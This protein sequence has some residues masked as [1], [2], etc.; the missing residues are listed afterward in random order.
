MFT[1]VSPYANVK[2]DCISYLSR[3]TILT[4]G[5]KREKYAKSEG[6]ELYYKL[7]REAARRTKTDFCT[8]TRSS[9]IATVGGGQ[10]SQ[11]VP[12]WEKRPSSENQAP[13]QKNEGRERKG[14]HTSLPLCMRPMFLLLA[15]PR[16]SL[17]SP[18]SSSFP[19]SSVVLFFG[20][21][22]LHLSPSSL[23]ICSFHFCFG[24]ARG[25]IQ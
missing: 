14:D 21:L 18:E 6:F 13:W 15:P 4:N 24:S 2:S 22:S 7:I 23:F 5:S 1:R 19:S 25:C 3:P 9:R 20:G 12:R 11:V 10:Q 16:P 17:L 8:Y